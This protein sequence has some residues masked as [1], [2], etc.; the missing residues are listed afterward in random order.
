MKFLFKQRFFSWFDSYD[1]YDEAGRVACKVKGELAWGHMFRIYDA[2]DRELG[3]V[4]QEIFSFMPRF[5]IY[6]G[7]EQVGSICREF[8]LFR[9][10][11]NIDFKNWHVEG[12]WFEWEYSILDT[13]GREVASITKEL[14][15]WTDTYSIDVHNPEDA[16]CALMLVLAIDAEKCSRNN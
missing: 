4:K 3:A 6:M 5:N 16:L 14:W 8:S 15:N 9:P 10:K 1:I 2:N 13:S 11:Y 7:G 12:D